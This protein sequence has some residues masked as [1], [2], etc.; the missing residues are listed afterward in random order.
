[1][2]ARA[3]RWLRARAAFVVAAIAVPAFCFGAPPTPAELTKLCTSAEDQAH[4]GRLV[5]ARRLPALKKVVTR[6]GDELRIA[7]VPVGLTVFRDAVNIVGARTYAV[8]DYVED[9]DAVVLFA[10]DGD[11]TEFWIVQRRGGGEFRVPSEPVLGPGHKRF[12]TADFCADTCSNELAVWRIDDGGVRKELTWKPAE[13]WS[14]AGVAW[15][16]AETLTVEYTSGR[17]SASRTL[18]RRLNDATWTRVR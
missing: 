10:T 17:D 14:D 15:K 5:E 13:P 8:W 7:L 12:A 18:E 16:G 6:E 11:R 2:K 9:L 4:C 1:V 3:G